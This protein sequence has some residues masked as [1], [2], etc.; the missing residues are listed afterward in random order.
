MITTLFIVKT[1]SVRNTVVAACKAKRFHF[2]SGY[3]LF[4]VFKGRR[5]DWTKNLALKTVDRHR[6][7]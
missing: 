2:A 3:E 1:V 7:V 4:D 6:L 5:L